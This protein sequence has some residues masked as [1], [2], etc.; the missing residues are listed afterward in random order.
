MRRSREILLRLRYDPAFDFAKARVCY[1]DRGA[2]DDTSCASGDEITELAT[3]FFEIRTPQ[4]MKRIPY[5]RIVE[6]T[7]GG[8]VLWKRAAKGI[9]ETGG[10]ENPPSF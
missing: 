3:Y 10:E 6:I 5:H 2:P 1:I 9:G 7:H 8:R 4:G